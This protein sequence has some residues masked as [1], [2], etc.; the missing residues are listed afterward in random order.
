MPARITITVPEFAHRGRMSYALAL[1]M[2]LRGEVEGT[3]DGRRW[4]I[5]ADSAEAALV[6]RNRQAEEAAT[7]PAA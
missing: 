5:Y 4:L 1:G 6:R 7:S 2:L 3:R